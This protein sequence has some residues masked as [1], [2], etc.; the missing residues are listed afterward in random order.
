LSKECLQC[1]TDNEDSSAVCKNCG[2]ALAVN[3]SDVKKP[4][5]STL[6][7]TDLKS[8][9]VITISGNCTIGRSGNVETE[10]FAEDMYVSEF[11]CKIILENGVYKVV[12]L[13]TAKNPTKINNITLSKGINSIIRDG[14]YFTIADKTFEISICTDVIHENPGQEITTP[15]TTVSDDTNVTNDTTKYIIMCPVCGLEYEVSDVNDRINEC[16]RCDDDNDKRE[17]SG[18]RAKVKYAN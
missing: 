7:M 1:A 9:K 2:A 15:D 4:V 16:S 5:P 10:Y 18:V 11:H 3:E 12:H 8:G 17:I 13:P 6:Q 14:D